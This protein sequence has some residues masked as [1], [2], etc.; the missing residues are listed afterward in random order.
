MPAHFDHV[1]LDYAATTPL[2]PRVLE[3]M[4]PHLTDGFGNP[5]SLH[6]AGQRTRRAVEEAR[7]RVAAAI[8]ALPQEIVFT[9]GATEADNHALRAHAGPLL[10][11]PLEHAAVLTTAKYLESSGRKVSYVRPNTRGEV[12]PEAVQEAL[13]PGTELVLTHACEQRNGRRNRHPRH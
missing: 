9:S 4:T 8:G 1:Y 12:T 6:A 2:E 11:S 13:Q 5:S 3:A 10:T 7:E